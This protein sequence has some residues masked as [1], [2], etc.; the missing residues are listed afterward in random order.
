MLTL[1]THLSVTLIRAI[2]LSRVAS[3][4]FA[5][6][7]FLISIFMPQKERGFG[8]DVILESRIG[9]CQEREEGTSYRIV[10]PFAA[11]LLGIFPWRNL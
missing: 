8:F 1:I 7:G 10:R 3:K 9:H 4:V 6:G 2:R 11:D 5:V